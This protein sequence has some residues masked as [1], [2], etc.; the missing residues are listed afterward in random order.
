MNLNEKLP[1]LQSKF[2]NQLMHIKNHLTK[3]QTNEN[4][5]I[6]DYDQ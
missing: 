2:M 4:L 6:N 3:I 5:L 1:L